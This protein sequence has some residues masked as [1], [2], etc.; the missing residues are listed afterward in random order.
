[1][2]IGTLR[3][4]NNLVLS[5]MAGVTDLVY[6]HLARRHGC[7]L[8]LTEMVSAAGLTRG[9]AKTRALL[10]R[11]DDERPLGVQLFGAEPAELGEAA[12]IAEAEGADLI[13][14]NFGC[15]VRKVTRYGAG[16]ALL[17][18]PRKVAEVVRSVR[19]A[20][21]VP[22]TVKIRM[23]WDAATLNFVEIGRIAEA[24]GAQA[25]TMHGRTVAQMYTGVA[26]WQAIGRLKRAVRIP[27]L[28]SGDLFTADAIVAM[29]RTSGADGAF[30]ARGSMGNPWIFEEALAKL[31]GRGP[32]VPPTAAQVR[33]TILT[34]YALQIEHFGEARAVREMRKHLAWYTRGLPDGALFRDTI[35]RL[36][37]AADALAAIRAYLD[38]IQ[39][40]FGDRPLPRGVNA[41][42]HDTCAGPADGAADRPAACAV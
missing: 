1:M 33:E 31:S 39:D 7:A 27:V 23:G 8:A 20:V 9:G 24:E 32:F 16:S 22:V 14:I 41:S 25:I 26:D 3:L 21:R 15:P 11:F 12:R 13:D 42:A 2:Q 17:R 5:P 30:V 4:A 6:R 19:R 10:R 28:G 37:S 36:E 40:R 38:R 35:N 34:H 29:L 18:E